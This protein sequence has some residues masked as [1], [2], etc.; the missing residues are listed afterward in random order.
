MPVDV[1]VV[2]ERRLAELGERPGLICRE[3]LRSGRAAYER[4]QIDRR[5]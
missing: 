5:S 1:L 4:E 3:V 2:S